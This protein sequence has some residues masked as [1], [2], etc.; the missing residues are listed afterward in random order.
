MKENF[1]EI[2]SDIRTAREQGT[3]AIMQR[4][5]ARLAEMIT[6]ARTNSPY[7]RELYQ[8]LPEQ[9]EDTKLLPITNKKNLMARF[10]D[11]VTDRE[12]TLETARAFVENPDTIGELLLGKYLAVIGSGTRG[13]R[14]IYLLMDDMS[15]PICAAL[16]AYQASDWFPNGEL[17][18]VIARDGGKATIVATSCNFPVFSGASRLAKNNPRSG[19]KN[20]IFSVQTPLPE[21]VDQLNQFRPVVLEGYA[22]MI[23]LLASE[24]EAG[25]LHINPMLVTIESE[26]LSEKEA[27]RVAR[28]FNAKLGNVYACSECPGLGY[29]CDHG[30]LHIHSDWVVFEPVDANY[31]PTPLGEPSHTVLLSNLYNRTQ[32]ILRY[33]LGDSIL[34]R[35]DPCPCGNPLPAIKVLGRSNDVLVF[36]AESGEKVT[37]N[38]IMLGT[39]VDRVWGIDLFQFVQTS[40]TSMRVRM[41]LST[42]TDPDRVWQAMHTEIKNVLVKN[43]LDHITIERADEPPE[44]SPGGKYNVIISAI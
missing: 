5:R 6:F 34:Q 17:I 30:W 39:E 15:G 18:R 43:N 33:D 4:Q 42:G 20:R 37:I 28:V 21:L 41:L 22:N 8:D 38:L 35:P 2:L 7:Y 16:T 24:Q 32:P 25:R 10:D 1:L 31:Q 40:P 13:L 12:V 11:W 14:G 9:V 36:S 23:G 19:K 3:E 26:R 44:Q 29:S 27:D